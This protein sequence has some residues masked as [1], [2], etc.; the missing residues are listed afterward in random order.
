[1]PERSG[2][3][4]NAN[5]SPDRRLQRRP[6]PTQ[7]RPKLPTIKLYIGPM[8][9]DTEMALTEMQEKTGMMFRTNIQD[10]DSMIFVFSTTA[11]QLVSG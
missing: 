9:L 8:V 10:S 3:A 11:T 4:P 2:P 1:M 5:A 7:P 6:D